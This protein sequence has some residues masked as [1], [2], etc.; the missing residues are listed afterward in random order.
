MKRPER[1]EP[2]GLVG[3]FVFFNAKR[4]TVPNHLFGV[5]QRHPTSVLNPQ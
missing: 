1:N 3:T 4:A 2:R 5:D